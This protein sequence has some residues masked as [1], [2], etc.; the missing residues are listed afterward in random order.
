MVLLWSSLISHLQ[1]GSWPTIYCRLLTLWPPILVS[2]LKGICW[3]LWYLVSVGAKFTN[4][5]D[6]VYAIDA[7]ESTTSQ[8][9]LR[10]NSPNLHSAEVY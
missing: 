5:E 1:N 9:R 3:F 6:C 7:L 10:W 8:P 4:F 2:N